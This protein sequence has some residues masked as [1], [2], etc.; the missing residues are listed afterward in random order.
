LLDN[1]SLELAFFT[2]IILV[3]VNG[4][5]SGH[6]RVNFSKKFTGRETPPHLASYKRL[7]GLKIISNCKN[8]VA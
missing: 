2:N 5:V 8:D 6:P 1:I 4:F 3:A 7:R